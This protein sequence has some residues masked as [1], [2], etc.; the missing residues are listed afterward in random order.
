MHRS[1]SNLFITELFPHLSHS[2]LFPQ[3]THLHL[4]Y[5]MAK[6][7]V[8]VEEQLLLKEKYYR[9]GKGGATDIRLVWHY[10]CQRVRWY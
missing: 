8:A 2:E 6:R 7:G 5:R 10:K 1:S 9:M 4:Q 3:S